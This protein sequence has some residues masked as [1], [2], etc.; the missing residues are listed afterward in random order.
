M[1]VQDDNVIP[2]LLQQLIKQITES[3][4]SNL[5]SLYSDVCGK[6]GLDVC[7]YMKQDL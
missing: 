2:K 3:S 1:A 6:D 5:D 4:P 7:S